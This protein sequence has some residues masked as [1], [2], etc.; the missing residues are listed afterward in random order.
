MTQPDLVLSAKSQLNGEVITIDN[1]KPWIGGELKQAR[2]IAF[3]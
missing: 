3:V 2:A 1:R